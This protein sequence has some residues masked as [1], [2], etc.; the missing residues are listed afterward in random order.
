VKPF[1]G[2][3][4]RPEIPKGEVQA[5]SQ[6]GRWW[7]RDGL[8]SPSGASRGGGVGRP[9]LCR[10]SAEGRTS[11]SVGRRDPLVGGL[12]L[13]GEPGCGAAFRVASGQNAFC[14]V[15]RPTVS[16]DGVEPLTSERLCGRAQV[17]LWST[18]AVL[19]ARR[20]PHPAVGDPS[21]RAGSQHQSAAL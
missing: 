9:F 11:P 10:T 18:P 2:K 8:R 17:G 12:R 13:G 1:R 20:V 14:P 15:D 7:F 4:R 6:V 21:P 5:L 19:K 16:G 3:R